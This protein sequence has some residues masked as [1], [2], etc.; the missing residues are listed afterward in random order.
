[1]SSFQNFIP[2]HHIVWL[3]SSS[4]LHIVTCQRN[5][6]QQLD[7]HPTTRARN[8][9]KNVYSSLLGNSERANGLSR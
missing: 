6:G 9:R 7:E 2:S 4:L 5:A 1:M 3:Y 8:N